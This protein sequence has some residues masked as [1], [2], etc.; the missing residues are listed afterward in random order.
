MSNSFFDFKQFSITQDRCAMKVTT[1]ACILGSWTPIFPGVKRVL[2]VGAGTGLLSL[3]LAQRDPRISVDAIELDPE[4]ARQAH[5]NIQRSPWKNNINVLNTD[6]RNHASEAKYDLVITNPPF[7]NNSL[8][9]PSSPRNSAR[10]TLTLTYPDLLHCIGNLLSDT[11]YAS[12]L[13]PFTEYKIFQSY[14]A[15]GNWYEFQTLSIKHTPDAPVKRIVTLFGRAS[16]QIV[17][18]DLLVIKDTGNN[19]TSAFTDLLSPYYLQ[20]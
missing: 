13:L 4:A 1:D 3:M 20:L 8:L 17:N 11:G 18:A 6:I 10:H 2:D 16:H 12:V 15:A 5:E 7:F 19:Y 14:M 9:G